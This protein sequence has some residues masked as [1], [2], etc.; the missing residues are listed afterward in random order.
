ML[1]ISLQ[2]FTSSLSLSV[3]NDNIDE[4]FFFFVRE[5]LLRLHRNKGD[6]SIR[7]MLLQSIKQISIKNFEVVKKKKIENQLFTHSPTISSPSYKVN[8]KFSV[9]E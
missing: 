8:R 3:M 7:F 9:I 2:R 4:V 6:E 5:Q 1:Y